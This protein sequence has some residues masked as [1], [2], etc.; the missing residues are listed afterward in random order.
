MKKFYALLLP[1]LLFSCHPAYAGINVIPTP[2][3]VGSIGSFTAGNCVQFANSGTSGAQVSDTGSACGGGGGGGAPGGSL[4]Q[5]QYNASPTTF[6]GLTI[7]G[8]CTLAYLTGI[9]TCTKTNG[10]VFASSA[11]TDTTTTA[12]ITDSTNKRFVTNAQLTVLGNTS[13]INTGDAS[14][15]GENYLT[16][17]G[18]AFTAH[19][20]ALGGTNVSGTLPISAGGTSNTTAVAAFNALTPMISAGDI[21]YESSNGVASRLPANS[22]GT[23]EYLRSVSSGNPL[24]AQVA[25]SDLSGAATSTQLPVATSA[26][27]GISKPDGLILTIDGLGAETVAKASPSAFGVVECGSGT[28]CTSGVIS[29]TGGT[30]SV[31]SVATNNG[32]TGGTIT[33]T[34]TL[35][36]AFISTSHA[37]CNNSGSDGAPTSANCTVSGT[38]NLVMASAPTMTNPV[39]GTQGASDN[40]TKGAST[41]YVTSAI[42]TAIAGVNPAVAVQAATTQASDTSGLTYNNGAGGI[43]ATFTGS[44]NTALTID[45]YT[46]TALGQRLL[47]KND[48]QSPSGAFN[49]V[50]YVT[51]VQ[52]AILPP[53]LTRALDYDQSSDINNTGAIPVANG[54]ANASTSW[55]LT[56]SVTTVGTDPLTYTKFSINPT[57]IL[58]NSLTSAHLFVGNGSNVATDVAASG[59]WTITN[60]GVNTVAKVN[61]V[62]YGSSPAT[63]GVPVVTGANAIT[64]ESVPNAALANSSMTI[65]GHTISLGGTQTIACADLSNGATGCSTA[66]GTSGATIPLLNA[67][68]TW[69]APQIFSSS[70]YISAGY[71]ETATYS[72]GNSGASQTINI[73][74]GSLQSTTITGAATIFVSAVPTHTGRATLLLNQDATGHSYSISG[75]KWPGGTAITYSSAASAVDIVSIAYVSSN[76]YCMGGAAFN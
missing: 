24:W 43:G 26:A 50:Y 46:F 60:A 76:F 38:G 71:A 30:G 59:D 49:G 70:L 16:L 32:L 37:L 22:T 40:S 17:S 33:T 29:V 55:L 65:A 21:E 62:S 47:V 61:G 19:A 58:T 48:T 42:S 44:N 6:G 15:S 3:A 2:N 67:S 25:F 8:D 69:S 52:T 10:V 11:T 20:V 14:L 34:G 5:I 74:N 54:T 53:I 39:V 73:D 31:S 57:I 66:T 13:G 63:N 23:N 51:Q 72:N 68:N 56:S 64:Y 35:G 7:S 27:L 18:Q 36:L 9:I 28:S 12:N 4:G 45:G 41:A 1:F 75:C